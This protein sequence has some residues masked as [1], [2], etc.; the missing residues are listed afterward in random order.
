M[1]RREMMGLQVVRALTLTATIGGFFLAVGLLPLADVIAIG[2]I[3]PILITILSVLFLGERVGVRHWIAILVGF[4]GVMII[5]RP[6]GDLFHWEAAVPLAAALGVAVYQTMTRPISQA[7]EP[8][9]ILYTATLVGLV[10]TSLALPFVWEL[11]S[12]GALLNLFAAACLGAGAHFMLIKAYQQAEASVVA[13]FSYS[14]LIW[15]SALGFAVFGDIPAWT[16]LAGGLVLVASG[17]YLLK[18]A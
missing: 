12:T 3:A 18:R 13:P 5:V 10:A 1:V 14:E 4:G 6:G 11:P 8:P 2:F 15:A 9:A 7:V 16:T 17:L